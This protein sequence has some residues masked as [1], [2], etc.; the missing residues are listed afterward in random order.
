MKNL[1]GAQG[2]G[3]YAEG[4]H[5]QIQTISKIAASTTMVLL[6]TVPVLGHCIISYEPER[7]WQDKID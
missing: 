3:Q 1:S 4:S 6:Y 2:F 7:K 5:D